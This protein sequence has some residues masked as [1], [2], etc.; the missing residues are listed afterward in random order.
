MS[1]RL[2]RAS[3]ADRRR[4]HDADHSGG[5][6]RLTAKTCSARQQ[7]LAWFS[8]LCAARERLLFEAQCSESGRWGPRRKGLQVEEPGGPPRPQGFGAPAASCLGRREAPGGP[9]SPHL[10]CMYHAR[11]MALLSRIL[12]LHWSFRPLNF[13][14]FGDTNFPLK[15]ES[16]RGSSV[17]PLQTQ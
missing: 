12:S 3:P 11:Q 2:T 1:Q 10:H 13:F 14:H 8:C 16:K 5:S 7:D 9:G 6:L 17:V 4:L 15:G